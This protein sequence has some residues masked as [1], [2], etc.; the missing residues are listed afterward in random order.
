MIVDVNVNLS[1]WPFRRL[2]CDETPELVE[3][4]QRLGVTQAWAGSFDGLLHRD[5]GGVNARLA[6]QCGSHGNGLLLAFGSV[7][8]KL[9]DWQEDLRRC[10]ED[11]R[12][13]GIRLHP[14][15]HGYKLDDPLFAKLLSLASQRRMIVQLAARMEDPRTHHPLM[16][17][18]DVDLEPL[19]DVVATLPNLQLVMLNSLRTVRGDLMERLIASGNVYF[20]LSML[21]GVAGIGNLLKNVPADRILFG[22]H[23]PFFNIESAIF[24]MRESELTPNQSR[25]IWHGNAERILSA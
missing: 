20:E 24:K 7:N 19:A 21:E 25:A 9:P 3:K 17:V 22:S 4:L 14:N 13:P 18:G 2:P 12:M 23:F 15:Y 16:P 10:H 1:R 6:E 5:V 11:H 8:P